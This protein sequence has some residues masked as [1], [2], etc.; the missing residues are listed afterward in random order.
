MFSTGALLAVMLVYAAAIFGIALHAER[1]ARAGASWTTHPVVHSLVLAVY[2]TTWT[3]YGSVGKAATDGPIFLAIYL[4]PTLALLGGSGLMRRIIALKDKHRLTSLADFVSS[5]YGKSQRV[6]ALVTGFLILGIVPYLAL[7]LKAV[8]SSLADLTDGPANSRYLL[9][10]VVMVMLIVFTVAF[11]MRR[12]DPA[13][14]H[15]GMVVSLAVEAVLKLVAFCAAGVFALYAGFGGVGGFLD[16]LAS[17]AVAT[18][19]HVGSAADIANWCTYLLLA[20]FAFAFLPR[21]FHVGIIESAGPRSIRTTMWLLPLYLLAINLFV[22]PIALAGPELTAPG[23]SPDRFVLA[24]PVH[25]G[26]V[27]LSL[28]VFLGGLSAAVGMVMVETMAMTTMISNHLLLPVIE[29]SSWL[30][31][32]RR[33]L[34]HMRWAIAA[35]FIMAGYLF[36]LTI[37]DSYMLVSMGILAMAAVVQCAPAIIIG[38]FWRR[39]TARGALAGLALG[40]ATWA[41]TLIVPTFVHSG[42]I[43]I[44]LL[45]HGPFG[46]GFLRPEALFGLHGLPPLVHGVLWSLA[47]NVGGLVLGSLSHEAGQEEARLSE[48]FLGVSMAATRA[49]VAGDDRVLEMVEKRG[50]LIAALTRYLPVD[51]AEAIFDAAVQAAGLGG[52]SQITAAEH[53]QLRDHVERTLAG[54]IGAAAAHAAIEA[55][56][57]VGDEE[58]RRLGEAYGRALAELRVPPAELRRMVDF[59]RE[60][61]TLLDQTAQELRTK[62]Q[63]RDVEIAARKEAEAALRRAHD[64]SFRALIES[65]PDATCVLDGPVVTY[66]NAAAIRIFSANGEPVAG[67]SLASLVATTSW[68]ALAAL[69]P[70]PWQEATLVSPHGPCVAEVALLAT[71]FG[72]RPAIVFMAHDITETRAL[73]A[74]IMQADRLASMGT[75]AA[76]VA[77]EVNNPL[78]WVQS[79]L[80][81]ARDELEVLL[82]NEPRLASARNLLAE[83]QDGTTRV[84]KI[85]RDLKAFT[86]RDEQGPEQSELHEVVSRAA[87][88][89]GHEIRHRAQLVLDL[90]DT[91]DAAVEPTQ[92]GQVLLNLLINAAHAIREGAASEN[93]ITVRTREMPGRRLAVEVEDTGTGIAPESLPHLF[94]AYFT[95]KPVGVGTGLGLFICKRILAAYGGAIE[96]ESQLGRGSTFRLVL[97]VA[98]GQLRVPASMPPAHAI[99]GRETASDAR[100]LKILLC[101]DEPAVARALS[102]VLRGHTLTSVRSGREALDA[103]RV[104]PDFDLVFCDLM[105]PEM[106]GIDLYRALVELGTFDTARVIFMTGGAFTPD[107]L[108][109]LERVTNPVLD[110]PFETEEILEL[111]R[112]CAPGQAVQL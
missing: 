39:A 89:A 79:S 90:R 92:L 3:Y 106:T 111:V 65:S 94:E 4:G 54:S 57:P 98:E 13:E 61:A 95:T 63:E 12:L 73:R 78:T 10:S 91:P 59:H 44:E 88:L 36:E 99:R 72:G 49:A 31:P 16:R 1:R 27:A 45:E 82:P 46:L 38:L 30:R 20:A 14:R 77:H 6:A 19:W 81:Q 84:V 51:Q 55:D 70:V 50:R 83:A 85:V 18:H 28:A 8:T 110:K 86:R 66:G 23:T 33:D 43:S 71:S 105:M 56:D 22:L 48:E 80:A 21:Q 103:I 69:Q 47:L 67:R 76:G 97:P 108:S 41:Y 62:M 5:R 11:G 52:H 102:R 40:A 32:L 112:R 17:P 34:L 25:A 104:Q 2:C 74:Q 15:P 100:S 26:H 75:L 7:Q 109:F 64:E 53:M 68:P 96:V 35:L 101:D 60:R 42:W 37:G 24:I 9:S 58:A 29:W 87:T 107:A 93:R